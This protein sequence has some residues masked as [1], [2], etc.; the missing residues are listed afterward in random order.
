MCLE[1]IGGWGESQGGSRR[2]QK[3][4]VKQDLGRQ[5]DTPFNYQVLRQPCVGNP[6][7]FQ[8]YLRKGRQNES[9]P[10]SQR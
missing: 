8:D 5:D 7:A 6:S 2:T 10:V 1:R 4:E 3:T 9:I